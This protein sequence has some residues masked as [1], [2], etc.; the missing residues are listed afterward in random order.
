MKTNIKKFEFKKGHIPWNK[1]LVG[2]Q[3]HS[4]KTRLKISKSQKG[5]K[6]SLGRRLSDDHKNKLRISALGRHLSIETRKKISDSHKKIVNWNWCGGNSRT[7][8]KEIR[9]SLEYK[10]VREKCFKRD[11]FTC[12]LCGARGGELNADHIKSFSKYPELRFELTNLRTLCI[13]CHRRT[14]NYG[15]RR[16]KTNKLVSVNVKIT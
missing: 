9:Q 14:P 6:Y 5:N 10:L 15:G 4:K 7:K 11:D 13:H 1:G 16:I 8:D 12:Q 2:A 3:V